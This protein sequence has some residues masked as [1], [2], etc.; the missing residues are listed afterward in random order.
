[1]FG[2]WPSTQLAPFD[3]FASAGVAFQC[4]EIPKT[5]PGR[6]T[7]RSERARRRRRA[8][9]QGVMSGL[10][11]DDTREGGPEGITARADGIRCPHRAT[12]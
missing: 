2:A 3:Q 7:R 6:R 11:L 5:A 4:I 1:L 10:L 9:L 8:K 12:E